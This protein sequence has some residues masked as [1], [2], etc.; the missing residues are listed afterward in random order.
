M[1]NLNA[2]KRIFDVF[3]EAVYIV[4]RNRKILYFNPVAE[5]ISG[6]K[7]E[8]IVSKH[9]YDNTLNHIDEH[10]KKLC[11]DGCPLLES[12]Q[13]NIT[14]DNFV[15]LHHKDGH[16]IRVHVRSVPLI[17]DLEVIG[18]IEVFTNESKT[19]LVLD[20][21]LLQKQLAL[22]DPL[23]G[24]FNRRYLDERF[25]IDFKENMT[26]GNLGLLFIDIDNFKQVNDIYG[27]LVGDAVL[28][29]VSSTIMHNLKQIDYVVRYGGEEILV[30]VK[31][32]HPEDL[33]H[34]ANQLRILIA[35][36]STRKIAHHLYV[37]V[38]IGASM[39]RPEDHI[40]VTI[41]HADQA[42]YQAKKCGKNQVVMI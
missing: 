21:L 42:M 17:E 2:M 1:T 5:K 4:D 40:T 14:T 13:E 22:I 25:D 9:C 27:H 19:N 7:A 35:A 3:H 32:T 12:I 30:L 29:T 31:E 16:R 15:Y 18:A 11:I 6:F 23:T 26:K 38:S 41:G 39:H 20:E 34:V 8:D 24:L 28:R 33:Y 10:G 36:S 37:T